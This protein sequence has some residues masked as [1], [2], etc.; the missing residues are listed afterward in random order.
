MF[1]FVTFAVQGRVDIFTERARITNSSQRGEYGEP[2][3]FQGDKE[4]LVRLQRSV[5]NL[6]PVTGLSFF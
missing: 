1:F 2:D 4:L 6:E 5:S 3:Y